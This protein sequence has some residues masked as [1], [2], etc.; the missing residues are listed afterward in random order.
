MDELF[1]QARQG[2]LPERF[3]QWGLKD[4]KGVTVAGIVHIRLSSPPNARRKKNKGSPA[5]SWG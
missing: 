3:G 2:T 1:K 5:N 4:D